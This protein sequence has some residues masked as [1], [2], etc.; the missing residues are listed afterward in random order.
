MTTK[1]TARYEES[2]HHLY[3]R[4]KETDNYE[5]WVDL[6][7]EAIQRYG[8]HGRRLLDLG[9]GTGKSSLTFA[10]RGYHVTGCDISTA[11][12]QTA[13][14]QDTAHLVTFQQADMR[15]LPAHLGHYDIITWMDDVA[16]HLLTEADLRTALA[17][18]AAHLTPGG[19]LIF[20]TNTKWAFDNIYT[21]TQTTD[22]GDHLF[23]WIG[24]TNP[25]SGPV[26]QI[27]WKA[28]II[29]FQH[30]QNQSWRRVD[31]SVTERYFR[32][33]RIHHHILQAGMKHHASYGLHNGT[34]ISPAD[35]NAHRKTIHIAGT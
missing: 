22:L 15:K 24:E 25:T 18:S 3:D 1:S 7:V 12:L 14:Q 35:D 29:A 5:K 21:S 23:I 4:M 34:L 9:C 6:L 27:L 10:R 32:P 16:N 26:D 31:G 8:N 11:M 20:D 17:A 30:L 19:I 2:L 33:D 13:R 28:R